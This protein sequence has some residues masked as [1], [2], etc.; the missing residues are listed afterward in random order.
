MGRKIFWKN[1]WKLPKFN[2]IHTFTDSRNLGNPNMIKSKRTIP[3]TIIV[4]LLKIL[5]AV[6]EKW[7]TNYIEKNN[8]LN[9]SKLLIRNHKG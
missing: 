9:T 7:H 2:E 4:N 8:K 6:I 1:V 3:K 5:K